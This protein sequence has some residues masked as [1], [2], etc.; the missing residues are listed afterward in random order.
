M[1]LGETQVASAD[2]MKSLQIYP[3]LICGDELTGCV[4]SA[5]IISF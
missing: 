4:V 5:K 3:R 1:L 2:V